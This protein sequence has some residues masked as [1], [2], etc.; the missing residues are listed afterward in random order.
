MGGVTSEGSG[1]WGGLSGW[2][3]LALHSMMNDHILEWSW[4]AWG[5]VVVIAIFAGPMI[6][7]TVKQGL[8]IIVGLPILIIGSIIEGL[9]PTKKPT[10]FLE[11]PKDPVERAQWANREGKYAE[12]I[13]VK[14]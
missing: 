5:L 8:I 12:D 1:F 6:C 14:N 13:E 3:T 11:M 2:F 10:Q 7:Q 9:T 4:E